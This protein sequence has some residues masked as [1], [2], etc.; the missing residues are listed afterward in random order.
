MAKWSFRR[1]FLASTLLLA[2]L[3]TLAFFGLA[4][5]LIL[6]HIDADIRVSLGAIAGS[7]AL[8][9]G[10]LV[11]EPRRALRGLERFLS[12]RPSAAEVDAYLDAAIA[13]SENISV[14]AVLDERGKLVAASAASRERR[15]EDLSGQPAFAQAIK[16]VET[17]LSPPFI[18]P[19]D[20]SV[21]IAAFKRTE[22]GAIAAYLKLDELS[23][24]LRR[25]R[26]SDG[27]RLALVDGSGFVVA[28]SSP[29]FVR[30]QRFLKPVSEG[31]VRVEEG[32]KAWF[33]T[34]REVPELGWRVIYYR[35]AQEALDIA[36][37]LGLYF[38][39]VGLASLALAIALALRMRA[40]F[41]KPFIEIVTRMRKMTAGRYD[42]KI[43]GDYAE[44][45]SRIADAFN[46][47][48]VQVREHEERIIRQLDEKTVLLH[49]VHHRVKNNLQIMSSLL[50]L[51]AQN[52]RDPADQAI[53]R[54]SQDRVYSM[55]LVHELLYQTEELSSIDMGLYVG[56]LTNYLL[57][58]HGQE[59]LE[60]ATEIEPLPFPLERAMPCGLVLTE[61]VT[62]ALKY[63]V[64]G[65]P[66]PF[67][68]IR[69]GIEGGG[70]CLLEVRDCGAGLPAGAEPE[71]SSSLGFSLIGSLAA[72]LGGSAEFSPTAPGE[73][74][75]GLTVRIRFPSA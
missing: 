68:G 17:V 64:H 48:S 45:F 58:A 29:I 47:M 10:R 20:G 6:K 60:V 75:P 55:S 39:L 38:G 42:E 25:L 11:D 61:M 35:D 54:S 3:P 8:E 59:R 4:G 2:L 40:S 53:M 12:K 30:E 24:F 57:S 7:A 73:S 66:H 52:I 32:S 36:K 28:H 13:S 34:S 67:L 44:E 72:Q 22:K 50:N 31:V 33:A 1:F 56:Q 16:G 26:I 71:K 14:L 74:W 62:N 65:A 49:E 63:G 27:D 15:G 19:T 23:G 69:L 43:I 9:A 18:S 70:I 21:T 46:A 37:Q 5:A 41:S 51:E